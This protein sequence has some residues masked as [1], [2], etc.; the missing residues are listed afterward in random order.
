MRRSILTSALC[1]LPLLIGC[2]SYSYYD[3]ERVDIRVG[4]DIYSGRILSHYDDVEVRRSGI[5]LKPGARFAIRTPDITQFLA[6]FEV[7]I[8]SGEGM[9]VH[10]R[11][12]SHDFDSTKGL[13][14]RYSTTGCSVRMPDGAT[15]PL[16][17]NA[18]TELQFLSL[19]NEAAL[20]AISVGCD[21]LFEQQIDLPGTAYV[22]FET[23]PGSSI[24]L[25]SVNFFETNIE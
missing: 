20:V 10:L 1:S 15:I 19:Y 16:E 2:G 13:A 21:R 3:Y 6:Q 14:F 24:E 12:V 23:L 18:G 4:Q 5:L 7:A 8:L 25:R 9:D 11:T 22:I 17:Y